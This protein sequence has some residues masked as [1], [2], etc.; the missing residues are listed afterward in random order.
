MEHGS[1]ASFALEA[2]APQLQSESRLQRS[3][4]LQLPAGGLAEAVPPGHRDTSPPGT[5]KEIAEA[6]VY[7][8]GQAMSRLRKAAAQSQRV[9]LLVLLVGLVTEVTASARLMREAARLR[10]AVQ[11]LHP[12]AATFHPSD[13]GLVKFVMLGNATYA[14]AYYGLGLLALH[15][16]QPRWYSLFARV[17]LASALAQPLLAVVAGQLSCV[18]MFHRFTAYAHAGTCADDAMAVAAA[19]TRWGIDANPAGRGVSRWGATASAWLRLMRWCCPH[20]H[21][22]CRRR[23]AAGGIPLWWGM[24]RSAG[25]ARLHPV[26]TSQ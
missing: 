4:F 15:S 19:A 16:S 14:C 22:P 2:Q 6:S 18:V 21:S 23:A 20:R 3:F 25:D 24:R 13:P 10:P 11:R 8:L 26:A 5:P 1:S 9:L 17:A 12:L 7:L